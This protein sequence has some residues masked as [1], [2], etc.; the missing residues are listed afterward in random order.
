[1]LLTISVL[2][3]TCSALGRGGCII[4]TTAQPDPTSAQTT[5]HR[6]ASNHLWQG[7]QNDHFYDRLWIYRSVHHLGIT[8]IGH[9]GSS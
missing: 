8:Q 4:T 5:G 9:D 6:M 7:F 1:M 2:I 3:L